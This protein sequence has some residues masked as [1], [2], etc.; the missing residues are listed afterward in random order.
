MIVV[1]ISAWLVCSLLFCIT[2]GLTVKQIND[3]AP[4]FMSD[5][6]KPF[7]TTELYALVCSLDL[8]ESV[9]PLAP[10]AVWIR[11]ELIDELKE[12]G[13]V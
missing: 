4:P 3:R 10:K 13:T 2:F 8:A 6:L 11:Q 5:R 1:S 9:E 12:R 7:L